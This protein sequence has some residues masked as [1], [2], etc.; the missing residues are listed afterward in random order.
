MRARP[1][2]QQNAGRQPPVRRAGSTAALLAPTPASLLQLQRLAGNASVTALLAGWGAPGAT[3]VQRQLAPGMYVLNARGRLRSEGS[4]HP[5]I[6]SLRPGRPATVLPNGGRKSAFKIGT[7]GLVENSWARTA[8]AGP[9][10]IRDARLDPTTLVGA[11]D[12]TLRGPRKPTAD[13]LRAVIA[14][15]TPDERRAAAA[16]DAFLAR[17][18]KALDSDTYLQVLPALGVHRTPDRVKSGGPGALGHPTGHDADVAIRAELAHEV[19]DAVKA[20]RQVEGEVSVVGDQD[21]QAAFDRQW[22]VAAGQKQYIGKNAWDICEA[23]VDVNL[24]KRHIWIHRSLGDLGTIIHEGMHKYADSL[25]RDE[26]IQ[27]CN[28]NKITHGG[29]SRLDEGITEYFTRPVVVNQL[30]VPRADYYAN[31]HKVATKLAA[32]FGRPTLVNAYFNGDFEGLKQ[33]FGKG[34]PV[35]AERLERSDWRWLLINGWM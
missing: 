12:A 21:F 2:H 28:V 23:F 13:E 11:L 20:G 34:W 9:G 17:A 18:K 6:E 33:A 22:V 3:T 29:T 15:A 32:R 4:R 25:L 5:K 31:E 24:P 7:S 35:F 16:D 14:W 8:S 26:Q 27:L 30:K 10:W 19:A 1:V